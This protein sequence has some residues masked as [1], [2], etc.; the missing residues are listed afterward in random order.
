MLMNDRLQRSKAPPP[1]V[2]T[3]LGIVKDYMRVPAKALFPIV[4]TELPMVT[5][6]KLLQK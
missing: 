1:I 3:E 5:E 6:V 4:I 2:V